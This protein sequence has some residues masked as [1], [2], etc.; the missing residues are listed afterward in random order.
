MRVPG[1]TNKVIIVYTDSQGL[2]TA[3]EK[4]PVRQRDAHL[5]TIW[6]SL[7]L[8]YELGVKRVV[9][10]WIPSHCGIPRNENADAAAREALTSYG[11]NTQRRVPVRYQN[12]VSYYR[13]KNKAH[14][15]TALQTNHS[16]RSA[17]TTAPANL[18]QGNTLGRRSQVKLAQLRT[19]VSNSMGWYQRLIDGG[20][21]AGHNR[22]CRW[23]GRSE[24]TVTHV[25]N[26]CADL[27]LIGLRHDISTATGRALNAACLVTDPVSALEYHDRAIGFLQ[28]I[29]GIVA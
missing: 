11:T 24:E 1:P 20:F 23:C 3:L 2:I 6:K 21:R 10:Q 12:I 27:Q 7:Y 13:E 14:Y 19:G 8:L 15:Q 18:S 22:R 16:I 29:G 9:F 4:G 28:R 26:E 25:Y 5:A 17:L